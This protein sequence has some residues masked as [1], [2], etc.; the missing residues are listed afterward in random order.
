MSECT[1]LEYFNVNLKYFINDKSVSDIRDYEI[2]GEYRYICSPIF[3]HAGCIEISS[4]EFVK[5]REKFYTVLTPIS[6][7]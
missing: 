5:Y 4:N 1:S 7:N 2:D 6:R 3:R